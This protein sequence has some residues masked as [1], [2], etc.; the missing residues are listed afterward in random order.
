[1]TQCGEGWDEE[2]GRRTRATVTQDTRD[3]CVVPLWP[4]PLLAATTPPAVTVGLP[5]P[6][7]L[8]LP[9][10][11][12]PHGRRVRLLPPP[13]IF[14]TSPERHH[15]PTS[16]PT[17]YYLHLQG[18]PNGTP[19]SR[20]HSVSVKN[21]SWVATT[22]HACG[23]HSSFAK[24]NARLQQLR[25]AATVAPTIAVLTPLLPAAGE[26]AVEGALATAAAATGRWAIPF[27][28]SAGPTTTTAVLPA[29]TS[30][31]TTPG[32][33]AHAPSPSPPL[34]PAPHPAPPAPSP[35][36]PSPPRGG[37]PRH[38]LMT[39]TAT[40]TSDRRTRGVAQHRSRRTR[41]SCRRN[42]RTNR[43][44]ARVGVP[45]ASVP[46]RSDVSTSSV[47][48]QSAG[49]TLQMSVRVGGPS[50]TYWRVGGD[51]GRKGEEGGG[52]PSPPLSNNP[53][54]VGAATAA[55]ARQDLTTAA[56]AP[57]RVMASGA[58]R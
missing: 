50:Y 58:T 57:S 16:P 36:A 47:T 7:R 40:V 32:G 28:L 27:P 24:L 29:S 3:V 10:S 9:P 44:C 56:A 18:L 41:R 35:P 49:R 20:Q 31:I 15:S 54:V 34:P 26:T 17:T 22:Q 48:R 52:L 46:H 12:Q 1:M 53:V 33:G 43:F 30:G 21:V 4:N 51:A 19:T 55:V 45:A 37:P 8:P 11:A 38:A 2:D 14:N 13:R 39:R 23:Q 42:R 6:T 25:R 5:P